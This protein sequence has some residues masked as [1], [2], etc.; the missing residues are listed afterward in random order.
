MFTI[1]ETVVE[2]EEGM[3]VVITEEDAAA[4][5]VEFEAAVEGYDEG[6]DELV[7]L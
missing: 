6:A 7:E 2:F 4:D 1:G 5:M 3:P